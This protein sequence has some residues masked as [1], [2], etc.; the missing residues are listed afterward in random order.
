MNLN[1][2]KQILEYAFNKT[3][4]QKYDVCQLWTYWGCDPVYRQVYQ[5]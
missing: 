1:V 4:I 3:E 5:V 2:I